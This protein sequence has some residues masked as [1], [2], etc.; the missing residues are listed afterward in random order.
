MNKVYLGK[1]MMDI[2]QRDFNFAVPI[3]HQTNPVAH[4][5]LKS[6]YR[7]LYFSRSS[8]FRGY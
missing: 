7:R 6:I 5:Q 3:I 2:L 1:S 8:N 4:R